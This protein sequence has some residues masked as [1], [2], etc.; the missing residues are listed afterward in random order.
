MEYHKVPIKICDAVNKEEPMDT[1]GQRA[2][3]HTLVDLVSRCVPS[4]GAEW[5]PY[6]FKLL[7]NRRRRFVGET[8]LPIKTP[9]SYDSAYNK[10]STPS[11]ADGGEYIN[12]TKNNEEKSANWSASCLTQ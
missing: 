1:G 11:S 2:A 5:H 9:Q 6:T 7:L 3:Y 8:L 4:E 10:W 12:K